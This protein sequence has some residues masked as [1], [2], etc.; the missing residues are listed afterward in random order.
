M[1]KAQTCPHSDSGDIS[2][3]KREKGEGGTICSVSL[4]NVQS[5]VAGWRAQPGSN[6]KA[7][8]RF[9]KADVRWNNEG[10]FKKLHDCTTQ[11][12]YLLPESSPSC[13][14]M[15]WHKFKGIELNVSPYAFSL[16]SPSFHS[17]LLKHSR[18][19]RHST[20][21]ALVTLELGYLK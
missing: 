7:N 20:R 17:V 5:Y 8:G 3:S 1:L 9:S 13:R 16:I 14:S 6:H 12:L 11:N 2:D 21:F 19:F 4:K 15:Q 18:Y 10:L